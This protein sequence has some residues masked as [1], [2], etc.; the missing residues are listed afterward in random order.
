M[1]NNGPTL[2]SGLRGTHFVAISPNT[3]TINASSE[4]GSVTALMIGLT[5]VGAASTSR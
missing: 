5:S 1:A 4:N 3:S 2:P